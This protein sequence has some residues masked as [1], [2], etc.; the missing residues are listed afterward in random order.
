MARNNRRS[1]YITKDIKRGENFTEKNTKRIRP[2]H[3]LAPKYFYDIIGKISRCD[4][5]A[6]TPLEW[7]FID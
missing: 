6:G 4:I 2:G 1:I 5:K 3:G 7:S